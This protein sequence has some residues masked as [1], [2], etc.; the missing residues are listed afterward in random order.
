MNQNMLLNPNSLKIIYDLEMEYQYDLEIESLKE[1]DGEEVACRSKEVF[2]H[3]G[4]RCFGSEIG[5]KE[6]KLFRSDSIG[7]PESRLVDIDSGML[8][9]VS[10][11]GLC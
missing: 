3:G 7:Y 6:E 4:Q 9:V 1:K 11:G 8:V 2:V 10:W 5:R